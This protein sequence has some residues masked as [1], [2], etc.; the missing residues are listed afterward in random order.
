MKKLLLSLM[1]LLITTSV[2]ASEVS[3]QSTEKRVSDMKEMADGMGLVMNGLLYNY[4][5]N[6][7]MG[8]KKIQ[9]SVK[10]IQSHDLKKYLPSETAYAYKFGEKSLRRISE[11]ATELEE[12]MN[13]KD[14][15]GAFESATLLM[16]QCNSCHSRVR[17]W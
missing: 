17:G 3:Y 12:A 15:E 10:R 9:G 14:Y 1:V 8:A 16:R 2:T 7:N 5:D 13:A 4:L 11:Y 6:V